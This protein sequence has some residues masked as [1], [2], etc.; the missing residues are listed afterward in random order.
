[1]AEAFPVLDKDLEKHRGTGAIIC[2]SEYKLK[3]RDN[4]LALPVEYI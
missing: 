1:M 3:L 2:T 4:L